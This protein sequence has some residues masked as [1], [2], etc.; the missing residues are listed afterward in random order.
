MT[1]PPAGYDGFW[2]AASKAEDL[3]TQVPLQRWDVDI[4]YSPQQP[5]SKMTIYARSGAFCQ[6]ME[7]FDAA[8]FRLTRPEAVATDPQQRLL[9]QECSDAIRSTAANNAAMTSATGHGQ[10][11]GPAKRHSANPVVTWNE[12]FLHS[13]CKGL[14]RMIV[15][16]GV[17]VGCMYQEYMDVQVNATSRVAP[18]AV[19]GS[20]LSFMVGRLSYTFNF[21]GPCVSTDTACSSSLVSTHLAVKVLWKCTSFSSALH[22]GCAYYSCEFSPLCEEIPKPMCYPV[23][24]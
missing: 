13:R 10:H 8:A 22:G 18:Q 5:P 14:L 12:H 9:L 24:M 2:H 23:I 17:Y 3:P 21:S 15:A 20:G 7:M 6:D 4:A 16:A 1:T 19:V 11:P